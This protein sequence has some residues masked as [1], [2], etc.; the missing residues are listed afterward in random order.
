MDIPVVSGNGITIEK[1]ANKEQV[2]IKVN[3]SVVALKSDLTSYAKTSDL[4]SYVK[5]ATLNTTLEDYVKTTSLNTI[6]AGWKP[7]YSS[8]TANPS[9]PG[10]TSLTKIE[11]DGTVYT[12]PSG[13]SGITIP[14]GTSATAM[15]FGDNTWKE[16]IK[17]NGGTFESKAG[18]TIYAPETSPIMSL[19]TPSRA[20]Y[21]SIKTR[22]NTTPRYECPNDNIP[23]LLT[24]STSVSNTSYTISYDIRYCQS[25]VILATTPNDILTAT[26]NP[27]VAESLTSVGTG[28]VFLASQNHQMTITWSFVERTNMEAQTKF[29]VNGHSTSVKRLYV[30]LQY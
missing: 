3:T 24:L 30:A 6:L 29:T 23:E 19:T 10:T 5:T 2:S 20:K 14:S 28:G 21:Y 15:L 18:K 25:V 22:G 7:T 8:V 1:A 13:S 16:P 27:R 11:I 4:A 9:G 12:I 17:I 26:I